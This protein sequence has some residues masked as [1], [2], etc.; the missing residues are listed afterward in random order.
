M[1][2]F[3]QN[4]IEKR[5][6]I[7]ESRRITRFIALTPRNRLRLCR[8]RSS[9]RSVVIFID[10]W[11]ARAISVLVSGNADAGGRPPGAVLY[12]EGC[13]RIILGICPR[14][15]A[16]R[17][18]LCMRTGRVVLGRVCHR[19]PGPVFARRVVDVGHEVI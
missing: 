11:P 3:F 4:D 9:L 16:L 10:L 18:T 8:R 14:F 5:K 17:T 15:V 2:L 1:K 7:R 13:C 6:T 12:N 19:T